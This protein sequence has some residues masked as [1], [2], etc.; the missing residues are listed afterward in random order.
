MQKVR[1]VHYQEF[2]SIKPDFTA[3]YNRPLN[4]ITSCNPKIKPLTPPRKD[5]RQ[6]KRLITALNYLII[7][8]PCDY[9]WCKKLKRHFNFKLNFITL[10]LSDVQ[11]HS[12]S[13]IYK[14]LLDP[15]LQWLSYEGAKGYVWKAEV[16][17]N[18]NLHYHITTNLFIH[19]LHIRDK[20][21][22]LQWKAGYLDNY[23]KIHGDNDANSTDVVSVKNELKAKKYMSK[24][25]IKSD[26]HKKKYNETTKK[27]EFIISDSCELNNH[28]YQQKNYWQIHCTDG[29]VREMKRKVE[30][31]KFGYSRNLTKI[32]IIY[33]SQSE[34]YKDCIDYITTLKPIKK[35]FDFVSVTYHDLI[36]LSK[37]PETLK[38]TI[39][40]QTQVNASRRIKA[41]QKK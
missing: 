25:L 33:D 12:D 3:A 16:Q 31:H 19:Y 17:N 37:C 9:V 29:T 7:T 39:L 2:I 30:G 34:E 15:F 18:G 14:K 40:Q 36:D 11:K 26:S 22:Y 35:H 41:T 28:Y 13:D 4:P 1:K 24:Y 8:S 5:N 6:L 23:E 32:K 21:N 27:K 38:N 10:T 20:W